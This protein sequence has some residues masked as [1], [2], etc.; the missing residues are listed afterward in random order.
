M[1]A[2]EVYQAVSEEKRA[3]VL[4]K[5]IALPYPDSYSPPFSEIPFG[6]LFEIWADFALKELKKKAKEKFSIL[7]EKAIQKL[8]EKI[9]RDLSSK[10]SPTM[11]ALLHLAR[12]EKMLLAGGPRENYFFFIEKI[13]PDP[14]YQ[15]KVYHHFPPLGRTIANILLLWI[16]QAEELLERIHRDKAK[17]EITFSPEKPLGNVVSL[18]PSLS[19]LH[20]GNRSV[21]LIEFENGL[22][23]IYKP[24]SLALD[25]AYNRFI[26][27]LELGLRTYQILD[28]KEYG[29][30][31]FIETLPCV[32]QEELKLYFE[33]LGMLISLMY[34]MEGTDCHYENVLASG[35]Q[36]VLIDLES[37]FHPTVKQAAENPE[38][39]VWNDSVFRTGFLPSFGLAAQKRMDISP[40][41]A[42]EEQVLPN[43]V[44]EWQDVNTDQMQFA[45]VKKKV[46]ISVPRPKYH[47]KT[48]SATPFIPDLL[49][50]FERMYSRIMNHKE[51]ILTWLKDLFQHPVRCIFRQTQLY[52]QILQRLTDPKLMQS[53]EET[54][55]TLDILTRFSSIKD[56]PHLKNVSAKEKEAL[57]HG[58]IPFFLSHPSDTDLYLGDEKVTAEF[59]QVTAQKKV[60]EKVRQLNSEDLKRQMEYIDHSLYFLKVKDSPKHTRYIPFDPQK[61]GP[62]WEDNAILEMAKK[63]GKKVL[64]LGQPL[65]D[66]TMA[67]ISLEMDP[68]ID[69]F[70]FQPISTNFYSGI[71]GIAFFL[72][73]LGKMARNSDIS[74]QGGE[75]LSRLIK[76]Y[77]EEK[78]AMRL[79]L[80]I[81][82][83]SGI[84]SLIYVFGSLGKLLDRPDYIQNAKYLVSLIEEKKIEEDTSLDI[85]SGSAGLILV[86]LSLFEKAP[87]KEILDLAIHA[88]NHLLSKGRN[89]DGMMGWETMEG[90]CLTGFSHGAAGIAYALLK[91]Y[92]KTKERKFLDA[93]KK[94]FAYENSLYSKEK[95]NWPDLRQEGNFTSCSWCHGAPGILLSR[96]YSLKEISDNDAIEKSIRLVIENL[97]ANLDHLCCGNFG[98]ISILLDA[99]KI[100]DRKDLVEIAKKQTALYLERY[101]ERET[102]YLYFDL[103][104][105][106][107]SPGFMQGLSGIGYELLRQTRAGESLPNALI[108]E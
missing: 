72:A 67:W 44:A 12:I 91:L 75:I 96:I 54:E 45:F 40:L 68:K 37:L 108:F 20:H 27:K 78:E 29:W 98:R 5:L 9:V 88:G 38:L 90:K 64:S 83:M 87:E 17:I 100:L 82:A 48:V 105:N 57:R 61:A 80:T 58:D 21:Y 56:S 25:A 11:A 101:K 52:S 36:P 49:R 107:Q 35:S 32:S 53:E 34:I 46:Q 63:I 55:K 7:G 31:E 104:E 84:G 103:P 79:L 65:T 2:E 4:E 95:G 23:L 76:P 50:G 70:V 1:H 28:Q 41:S 16:E 6:D 10:C 62:I 13:F 8:K 106:I 93:A 66:G 97:E 51:E 18:S 92:E 73:A 74:K 19:D 43:P 85:I 81:G 77:H 47:G 42:E 3:S 24:K 39:T 33:R 30:V 22:K 86:L 15:R 69:R 94:G 89:M 99:G 102:F 71:S 60:I 14:E 26:G 59:F